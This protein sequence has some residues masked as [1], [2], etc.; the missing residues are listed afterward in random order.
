MLAPVVLPSA[1]KVGARRL[2]GWSDARC[3]YI[4]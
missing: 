2:S 4:Q 1:E 3:A